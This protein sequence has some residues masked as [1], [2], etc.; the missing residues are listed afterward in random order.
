MNWK[1]LKEYI[2]L[3]SLLSIFLIALGLIRQIIYYTYFGIQIQFYI[4]V[5]ELILVLSD[6]LILIIGLSFLMR[7]V[8]QIVKRKL[9]T[10]REKTETLGE[11]KKVTRKSYLFYVVPVFLI[12]ITSLLVILI[13]HMNYKL[14]G[15]C[16][17][18]IVVLQAPLRSFKRAS[19]KT[20]LFPAT[21]HL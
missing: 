21:K 2:P 19:K 5:P 13:Y 17:G 4:T 3:L 20:E 14:V 15:L 10:L 8:N 12:A 16:L 6:T 7:V 11:I 1:S 18:T 9:D